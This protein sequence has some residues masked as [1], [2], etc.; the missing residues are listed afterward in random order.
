MDDVGV[1]GVVYVVVVGV[2]GVGGVGGMGVGSSVVFRLLVCS[3]LL[4][5]EG[6]ES[7]IVVWCVGGSDG[8][9]K[10]GA[11]GV[12]VGEVLYGCVVLLLLFVLLVFVFMFVFIGVGR[13]G[14]GTGE[15]NKGEGGVVIV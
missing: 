10:K 5:E 12:F 2:S 9:K 3:V 7:G 14:D 15:S 1:V 13:K 8:D 4:K 6:G 11:S